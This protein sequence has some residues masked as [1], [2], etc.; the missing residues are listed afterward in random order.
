MTKCPD[1]ID[2]FN[3]FVEGLKE[4]WSTWPIRPV[5]S[6]PTSLR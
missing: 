1:E 3:S 5:A 4:G 2:F 6:S